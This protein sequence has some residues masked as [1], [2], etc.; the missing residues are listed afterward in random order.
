MATKKKTT[1]PEV[2]LAQDLINSIADLYPV[3][4]EMAGNSNYL[5][6]IASAL[7]RIATALENKNEQHR[8]TNS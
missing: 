5:K 4:D 1:E 6:D 3:L 2:V 8:I 7:A